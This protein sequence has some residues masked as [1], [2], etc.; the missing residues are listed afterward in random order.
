MLDKVLVVEPSNRAALAARLEI[1]LTAQDL[2]TASR[3]AAEVASGFPE[4]PRL[5]HKAAIAWRRAGNSEAAAA[6][7]R[8]CL[9][10]HECATALKVELGRCLLLQGAHD[11]A[12]MI[13]DAILQQSPDNAGARL[14][15]ADAHDAAGKSALALKILEEGLFRPESARHE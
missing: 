15:L 10:V 9:S 4:D 8:Q 11:E 14:G 7:L 5:V 6:M 12:S 2:E 3:L 1:A 13:F